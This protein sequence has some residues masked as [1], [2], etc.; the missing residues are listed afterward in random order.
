MDGKPPKSPSKYQTPRKKRVFAI[1]P[2]PPRTPQGRVFRTKELVENRTRAMIRLGLDAHYTWKD[3]KK[4]LRMK[5]VAK[6]T[7]RNKSVKA[8]LKRVI[9]DVLE[10]EGAQEDIVNSPGF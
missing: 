9:C 10:K 8:Y 3:M 1:A 7:I 2:T 6:E 4:H 5:G